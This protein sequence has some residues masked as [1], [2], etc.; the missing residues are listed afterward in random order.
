L[1]V[2]EL[3]TLPKAQVPVDAFRQAGV[4]VALGADDPLIF[5]TRLVGQYETLRGIHGFDDQTLTDFA[6]QAVRASAAPPQVHAGC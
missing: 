4:P 3:R 6:R 1:V 2:R 5:R